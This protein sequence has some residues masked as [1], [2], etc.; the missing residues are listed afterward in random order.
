MLADL[1]SKMESSFTILVRCFL[2][3]IFIILKKKQAVIDEID[4]PNLCFN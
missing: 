2:L 1:Q 4:L 3:K